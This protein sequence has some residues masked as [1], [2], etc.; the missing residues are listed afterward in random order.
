M[1]NQTFAVIYDN[2]RFMVDPSHLFNASQKFRD[3]I[4]ERGQNINNIYL[5]ISYD[6]FSARNVANFLKI[7]Q[8]QQTD[9]QNSELGE[10][11]LIAKMFQADQIYNTGVDFIQKNIDSNFSISPNEFKEI[12]GNKY[13]LIEEEKEEVHN[14]IME[15]EYVSPIIHPNLNE[16]EFDDS[17]EKINVENTQNEDNSKDNNKTEQEH[18]K[19][20]LHSVYY[21]IKYDSQFMKCPRF[22]FSKDGQVLYMAKQKNDEIFIGAGKNFHISENKI[23]N[24]GKIKRECNDFN[25]VNTDE[26]EFKIRFVKFYE[27]YSMNLSFSHKGTQ[28]TWR[29]KQPINIQSFSG[30]FKHQ[31]IPSKKNIILQNSRN[32][33]TYILR[34]MSK[35]S[36]ECECHPAVNPMVAFAIALSQITGP[37]SI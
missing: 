16:L 4:N 5:K 11:C 28:F 36:Y 26:Q 6:G 19:K 21:E 8:N 3:L 10:I 25:I 27:K 18:Q 15:S 37:I 17:R 29:P 31:P 13:L 20:K 7:C 35:K 32:H 24:C 23:E 22:Y 12:N 9:V 34:K 14:T 30:E 33:P 2:E 1:T